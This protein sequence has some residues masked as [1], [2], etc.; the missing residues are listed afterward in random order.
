M[1]Y[2]TTHF[3]G[4]VLAALCAVTLVACEGGSPAPTSPSAVAGLGGAAS[5]PDGTIVKS[6]TPAGLAPVNDAT[7]VSLNPTLVAQAAAPRFGGSAFAHRFQVSTSESFDPVVQTGLGSFDTQ[8]IMRY[9]LPTALTA[10]TKYYWRVRAEIE[11]Q[12][13]PW[14]PVRAFTTAGTAPTAPTPTTPTTPTGPRTANP[15]AGQRLPLP[16]LRGELAKFSNAS[17]SCP[18]GIQY[19]NNPWLDRVI[20]H[21][22]TFDTR[23]GYNA[24]P[25]RGPSQNGGRP[26]IAAGDEAAYNYGSQAD[27]GTTEVHLV[28]MLIAHCGPAPS[29]GWRIFTGEEPGRWTGVGRF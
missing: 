23:W 28:D 19:Q 26:V 20:D 27:E 25:T 13:G 29:L 18:G 7:S 1:M 4:A 11:D 10:A 21:F 9:T 6:T 14:S 17:D 24:K 12:G 8:G 15:A 3:K 22:R 16:D 2:N 5:N